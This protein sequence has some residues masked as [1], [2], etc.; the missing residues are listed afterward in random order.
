MAPANRKPLHECSDAGRR[1]RNG[2]PTLV[3]M[4]EIFASKENTVLYLLGGGIL[5][6]LSV[7]RVTGN[8]GERRTLGATAAKLIS[9]T[10]VW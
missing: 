9:L 6:P 4:T 2:I 3:E 8:A 7:L 10:K 5:M 1:Y